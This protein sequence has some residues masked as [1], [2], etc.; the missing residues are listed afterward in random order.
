[1]QKLAMNNEHLGTL[2]SIL[3]IRTNINYRNLVVFIFVVC[4]DDLLLKH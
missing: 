3:T 2:L 4:L 1:M